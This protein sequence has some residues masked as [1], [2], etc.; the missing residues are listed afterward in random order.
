MNVGL[1]VLWNCG[2]Y[3]CYFVHSWAGF[4]GGEEGGVHGLLGLLVGAM[5][6]I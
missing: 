5:G 2:A 3:F 1:W 6:V 4:L